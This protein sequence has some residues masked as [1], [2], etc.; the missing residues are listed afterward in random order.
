MNVPLT[1][2]WG[3]GGAGRDAGLWHGPSNQ[4]KT[5]RE[6]RKERGEKKEGTKERKE[7]PQQLPN[8]C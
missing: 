6:R 5:K 1:A 2:G 3:F 8:H 4:T 7:E